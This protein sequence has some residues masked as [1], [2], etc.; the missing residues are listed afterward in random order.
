MAIFGVNKE[1][2]S[3]IERKEESSI[4]PHYESDAVDTRLV[5]TVAGQAWP[6]TYFHRLVDD[7][8]SVTAY[9]PNLNITL[10]DY[11]R[12]DD[13]IIKVDSAIPVGTP[14]GMS[15]DGIIDVNF[16]P[17]P[18]DLFLVKS[19]DGRV[20][21]YVINAISRI[22]YNESYLFKIEYNIQSEIT[23]PSDP[24]LTK[25]MGA[26]TNEFVYNKD[27]RINDDK[28]VYSKAEFDVR[29]RYLLY[30]ETLM[31]DWTENFIVQDNKSYMS[32]KA[33][34]NIIFD[35]NMEAFIKSTI[36]ISNLPS[37]VKLL[38]LDVD[39]SILDTFLRNDVIFNRIKQYTLLN[40]IGS[41]GNNPYLFT[42][43]YTGINKVLA[44]TSIEDDTNVSNN[45][46]VN[47]LFPKVDNKFYIFREYIYLVLRGSD[48]T[49]FK[50]NLTTF[51]NMVLSMVTGNIL[52]DADIELIYKNI[53]QLDEQERFYFMPIFAYM[54]RYTLEVHT[55]EFISSRS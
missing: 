50:D 8:M 22:N 36:G 24:I 40:K 37:I 48:I 10:Q 7:N 19:P 49:L 31:N 34:D 43:S 41:Y 14:D 4:V 29:E 45:E 5:A 39:V 46:V 44:L 51:E 28:P 23:N 52:A 27:F 53:M 11:N 6:V 30:I 54:L 35:P 18:N 33:G 42:I 20:F 38:S 47:E 15:G 32:Y 16:V 25:L 21:I 17:N 26:T 1:I 9:D 2:N 3:N 13:F 12:I 55:V